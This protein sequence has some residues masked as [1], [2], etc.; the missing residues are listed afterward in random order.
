MKSIFASLSL[1]T[2]L[3]SSNEYTFDYSAKDNV[4]NTVGGAIS[5]VKDFA[6]STSRGTRL[7]SQKSV[8]LPQPSQ[9]RVT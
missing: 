9:T 2:I 6:V 8:E 1:S 4:A 5:P 3:L 7:S